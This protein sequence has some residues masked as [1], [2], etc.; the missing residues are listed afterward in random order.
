LE[1]SVRSIILI[2][3]D[4][5]VKRIRRRL[6]IEILNSFE[7]YVYKEI[8]IAFRLSADYLITKKTR[9]IQIV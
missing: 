5:I 3:E 8:G 9:R 1:K 2:L 7:E 4:S 6:E